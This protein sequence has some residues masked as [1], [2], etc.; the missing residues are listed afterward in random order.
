MWALPA[1]SLLGGTWLSP[2]REPQG[3]PSSPGSPIPAH[4]HLP[5]QQVHRHHC[6]GQPRASRPVW[7]WQVRGPLG[8][9][10]ALASW[11]G[12]EKTRGAGPSVSQ[13]VGKSRGLWESW[14]PISQLGQLRLGETH[15]EPSLEHLEHM[16]SPPQMHL[17]RQPGSWPRLARRPPWGFVARDGP[18][19]EEGQ[20]QPGWRNCLGELGPHN[21]Q[22][23]WGTGPGALT[24]CRVSGC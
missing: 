4:N 15:S 23:N 14:H 3:S 12:S 13:G 20:P 18:G 10:Q 22:R 24:P 5:T 9:S 2:L 7:R 16:V 21:S 17:L 19:A 8:R 1:P 6:P 11:R